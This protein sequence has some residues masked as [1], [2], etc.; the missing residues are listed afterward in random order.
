T[1]PGSGVF[2]PLS[3]DA[4]GVSYFGPSSGFP[5]ADATTN[6]KATFTA[7]GT[8]ESTVEI[9]RKSDGSTMGSPL[10]QSIVV[11]NPDTTKPIITI[12]PMPPKFLSGTEN[13][14]ITI[15]DEA[16]DP[17]DNKQ[18]WVELYGDPDW[19]EKTGQKVNLSSGTGIFT[20]N[21]KNVA[22]GKYVL[23]V[24]SVEDAAGNK[25]GDKSFKHF[26]VDNTKP[27]VEVT[28][29]AG[30]LLSGTVTFD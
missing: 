7:P 16:L 12:D 25:S 8:Y 4:S 27:V 9:V 17:N 5:V 29:V 13:F 11:T 15:T 21:T 23:R 6:L 20:V 3:F 22:D 18:I 30:S 1:F 26:I 19:S 28:P 2:L 24:G 10:H 14:T